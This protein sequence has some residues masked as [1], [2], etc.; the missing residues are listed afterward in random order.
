MLDYRKMMHLY[1]RG[2][3]KNNLATIFGCKWET[4]DRAITRINEM[5]G[6]CDSIPSDMTN[7][8]I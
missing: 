4:V 1:E 8:Q 7:D 5:W 6:D 2:A 3:S